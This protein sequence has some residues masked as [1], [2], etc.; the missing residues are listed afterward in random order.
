MAPGFLVRKLEYV[1]VPFTEMR[2][3]SK[4]AL[5][6]PGQFGLFNFEMK[7]LKQIDWVASDPSSALKITDLLSN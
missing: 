5:P 6:D 2:K 1:V 4:P 7:I 3:P